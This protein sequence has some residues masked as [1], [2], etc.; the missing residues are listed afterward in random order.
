MVCFRSFRGIGNKLDE[1]ANGALD[2][3]LKV[4][5]PILQKKLGGGYQHVKFGHGIFS[6]IPGIGDALDNI[7]NTALQI[8]VPLAQAAVMKRMG[9]GMMRCAHCSG[10][11]LLPPGY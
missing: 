1:I 6:F 4:G 11:G 9:G 10:C 5:M 7:G 2:L 3:G 8:G